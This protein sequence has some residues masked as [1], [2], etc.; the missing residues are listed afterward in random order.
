MPAKRVLDWIPLD[1]Q[2]VATRLEMTRVC[3]RMICWCVLTNGPWSSIVLQ[4]IPIITAST[5]E[6]AP[7]AVVSRTHSARK[8]HDSDTR[9]R[10]PNTGCDR[11]SCP[12]RQCHRKW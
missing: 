5:R 1:D 10:A 7:A 12:Y 4:K 9:H 11:W 8:L 6:C 2:F 3:G